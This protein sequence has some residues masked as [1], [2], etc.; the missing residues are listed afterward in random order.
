MNAE[1]VYARPVV[2]RII[3]RPALATLALHALLLAALTM[4]F[5]SSEP[6]VIKARVVPKAINAR[7]VSA[8]ELQPKPQPKP[9]QKPAPKKAAPKPVAK[10][11]PKPAPKPAPKVAPKVEAKP[12][13]KPEPKQEPRITDE[14]LAAIARQD[15]ARVI[16]QEDEALEATATAEEMANSYAALIQQTVI[17]YWSR[18]PSARNGME[19]ELRLQLVPTG[20]IVSVQVVRSSGNAAFD[21]SAMNAVEKAGSFPELR[22][23]PPDEFERTFRRFR[24]LFRPEDLRY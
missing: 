17:G 23:L 22:N 12:E 10:V 16:S 7:L 19:V 24:L 8:S 15:L 6:K 9:V 18:P 1:S 13:P 11:P 4:N 3:L 2:P 21:R 20:E 14:E 5:T